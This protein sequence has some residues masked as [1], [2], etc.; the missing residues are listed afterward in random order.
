DG[1][2]G[3][4]KTAA[5]GIASGQLRAADLD[6]DHKLDLVFAVNGP[7]TI[8]VLRGN[9]DGTFQKAVTYTGGWR[10]ALADFNNDG[11]LDVAAVDGT[12]LNVLLNAHDGS[13][14]LVAKKGQ[15]VGKN[16]YDV[17]AADFD[18]N[19]KMDVAVASYDDN[20]VVVLMGNGDGTFAA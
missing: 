2:F 11:D 19:G 6:G 20:T 10:V 1:T 16:P 15:A 3:R 12:N 14:K 13:G 18:H 5:A 7:N 9:G 17:V 8:G 4:A